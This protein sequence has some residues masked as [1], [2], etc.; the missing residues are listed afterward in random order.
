MIY[1]APT[2][3]DIAFK[4]EISVIARARSAKV[5]FLTGSRHEHPEYL[6]P[7]HLRSL[8][9]DIAAHDVY[10]CGP[11]QMTTSV[12]RALE[13]LGVPRRHIHREDFEF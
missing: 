2:D 13:E 5:H 8:V 7:R 6:T 9:P 10:V 3:D 11:H 4:D 1:R 12:A